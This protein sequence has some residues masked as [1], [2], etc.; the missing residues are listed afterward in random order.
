MAKKNWIGKNI[1][2]ML[3]NNNSSDDDDTLCFLTIPVVT[4]A[5]S[6]LF[7]LE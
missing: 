6:T 3:V 7:I 1:G 4:T 5:V 2:I